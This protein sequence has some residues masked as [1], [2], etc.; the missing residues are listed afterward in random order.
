VRC[1]PHAALNG[2]GTCVVDELDLSSFAFFV[3]A[4]TDLGN[5]TSSI[6]ANAGRKSGS[7]FQSVPLKIASMFGT[8]LQY[9]TCTST[10]PARG[11][12]QSMLSRLHQDDDNARQCFYANVYAA[13]G[14]WGRSGTF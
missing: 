12:G 3:I 1:I 8:T 11:F 14:G 10:S 7:R 4:V 9:P 2:T 13:P 5:D 6:E